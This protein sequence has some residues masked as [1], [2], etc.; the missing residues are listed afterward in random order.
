MLALGVPS[1]SFKRMVPAVAVYLISCPLIFNECFVGTTFS[2]GTGGF[3]SSFGFSAGFPGGGAG[4]CCA[5]HR[6]TPRRNNATKHRKRR[7]H[8]MGGR[9][10]SHPCEK[11]KL[12]TC[13]IVCESACSVNR[14]RMPAAARLTGDSPVKPS[15]N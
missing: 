9:S 7:Q 4:C 8:F 6:L 15:K 2:S 12:A 10:P 14:F 3:F 11:H 1:S 13:G 5:K